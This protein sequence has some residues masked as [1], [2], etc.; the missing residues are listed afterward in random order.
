MSL[1]SLWRGNC[2]RHVVNVIGVTL[3]GELS[4]TRSHVIGVT[5]AKSVLGIMDVLFI[6][7]DNMSI[8]VTFP[9][10]LTLCLLQNSVGV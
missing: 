1:V 6:F 8:L 2:Q 5:L 9:M 4:K 3:A 10:M 7:D